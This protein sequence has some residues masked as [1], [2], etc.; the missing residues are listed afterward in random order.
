MTLLHLDEAPLQVFMTRQMQV[1]DV[2][3]QV[4]AQTGRSSVRCTSFSIAEEFLTRV[5]NIRRKTQLITEFDLLLDRKATNKT[6][7]LWPAIERLCNRVHLADNHSKVLLIQPEKGKPVAVI[8]SQN[9]TR[10]NR[11][12]AAVVTTDE[13]A[14]KQLGD[15]YERI[16][17]S[18]SV[19]LRKQHESPIMTDIWSLQKSVSSRLKT[20]LTWLCQYRQSRT[21]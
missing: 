17:L 13:W 6:R 12:E 8:T 15:E 20:L 18:D 4:L 2:L 1:T 5:H 14:Y 21:S 19:D 16:M 3:L 7:E 11:E 9:M 10:G